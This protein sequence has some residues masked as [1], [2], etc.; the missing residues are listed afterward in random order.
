VTGSQLKFQQ[1]E[2]VVDMCVA[3]EN[4]K[5]KAAT[6][7]A[8]KAS[9]EATKTDIRNLMETLRLTQEQAMD[10]LKIPEDQRAEYAQELQS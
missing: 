8:E 9:Q 4:M 1:N 7:A 3:I 10:A 6:A 5:Q 2:E